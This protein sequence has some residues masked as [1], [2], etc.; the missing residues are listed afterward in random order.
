MSSVA[1]H[2]SSE[3]CDEFDFIPTEDLIIWNA[4]L[5]A[6]K[7]RD[8]VGT[9]ANCELF[10]TKMYKCYKKHVY[11]ENHNPTYAAMG[12]EKPCKLR[13]SQFI[14]GRFDNNISPIF[15]NFL[16]LMESASL[17][18]G[19]SPENCYG[20]SLARFKVKYGEDFNFHIRKS[21]LENKEDV[22]QMISVITM[23][24]N[25]SDFVQMEDLMI[26]KAFL[27]ASKK[28]TLF[29]D[30]KLHMYRFYRKY[31]H[32]ESKNTL[33]K[34]EGIKSPYQLRRSKFINRR[35]EN[36]IGPDILKFASI[37]EATSTYCNKSEEECYLQSVAAFKSKYGRDF[38]F[39]LRQDF[40]Q[41]K[42]KVKKFLDSNAR[43]KSDS[44]L[45][46]FEVPFCGMVNELSLSFTKEDKLG[47]KHNGSGRRH[48]DAMTREEYLNNLDLKA[49]NL[50]GD[51][52]AIPDAVLIT[53]DWDAVSRIDEDD[54]LVDLHDVHDESMDEKKTWRG[55]ALLQKLKRKRRKEPDEMPSQKPEIASE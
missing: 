6:F 13:T 35:F 33:Y 16:F 5:A 22:K 34:D 11:H 21:H 41:H 55:Q 50:H 49:R 44:F 12:I 38:S 51:K 30:V 31:F 43:S 17:Y 40:L 37:M 1:S 10:R 48:K 46:Y 45:S 15:M 4:F 25:E 52:E 18:S 14:N 20:D 27:S 39:N 42:N 28:Y 29:E 47:K 19:C 32:K 24:K 53:S 9:N 8:D 2:V 23:L 7:E 36:K 3:K 54:L 26:W